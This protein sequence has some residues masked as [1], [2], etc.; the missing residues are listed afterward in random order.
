MDL[1]SGATGNLIHTFMGEDEGGGFAHDLCGAGD[2]D[3]DGW[4]DLVVGAYRTT[5][6]SG[7]AGRT[8]VFA[9]G[10]PDLD[11]LSGGF[12]NCPT[13]PNPGQEDYDSDGR[14]DPC[15]VCPRFATSEDRSVTAGDTDADGEI[16]VADILYLAEYVFMGGAEPQPIAR[17]ADVNCTE[18]VNATDLVHLVHYLFRAGDPPCDVCSLG[19]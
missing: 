13:L 8:Y 15:D 12:D 2:V 14:G 3:G 11:G 17:A 19:Y 16:T 6:A 10:D 5:V 1:Y 9:L 7:Y 4:N 18:L